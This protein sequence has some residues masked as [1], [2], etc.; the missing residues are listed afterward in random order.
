MTGDLGRLA[1]QMKEELA[2]NEELLHTYLDTPG[3]IS[4]DMESWRNELFIASGNYSRRYW[5]RVVKDGIECLNRRG[6]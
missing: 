4:I 5:A 6:T 3:H 2:E 1:Q